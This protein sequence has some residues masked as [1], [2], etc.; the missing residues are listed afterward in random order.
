MLDFF[1]FAKKSAKKRGIQLSWGLPFLGS[2]SGGGLWGL[3]V[4]SHM[5]NTPR[6]MDTHS[7]VGKVK[8][9]GF[10]TRILLASF[11]IVLYHG[12]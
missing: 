3:S 11:L 6:I 9:P 8:E 5:Y 1:K 2:V 10:W 12:I 7:W 4:G